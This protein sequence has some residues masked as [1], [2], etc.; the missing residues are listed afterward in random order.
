MVRPVLQALVLADHVYTDKSGKK[1]IA[2]TFNRIVHKPVKLPEAPPAPDPAT[3]KPRRLVL[4]GTDMGCPWFY[5]SLTDVVDGTKL[6]LQ[7]IHRGRNEVLFDTAITI[8]N[9]DRLATIEIAYQLPPLA[10]YVQGPGEYA[11]DVISE[12]IILG[13]HRLIVVVDA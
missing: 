7:F 13:S 11:F 8:Q 2:G 5:L 6:L 1:I 3:G 9:Q 12:G 4:G 10:P